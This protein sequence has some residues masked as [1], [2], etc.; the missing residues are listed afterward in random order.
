MSGDHAKKPVMHETYA[1]LGEIEG[2]SNRAFGLTVGGILI[3]F[4]A[5]GS[6]LGHMPPTLAKILLAVGAPLVVL[7]FL[8]PKV[9]GPLNTLWMKF[10][11]LLG[12]IVTPILMFLIYIL[13]FTPFGVVMR[14][15]GYDPLRL[16]R[17]EAAHSYW[18]ERDPPG[19]E[20]KMMAEQF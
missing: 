7:G 16:R 2:P 15:R 10:G 6:L 9:L 17:D 4:A 13:M 3:A 5:I 18:V 8:F 12:M 14:A 11:L 1:E 20:P 19:P